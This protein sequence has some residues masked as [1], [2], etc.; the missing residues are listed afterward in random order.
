MLQVRMLYRMLTLTCFMCVT[1]GESVYN[2]SFI[3]LFSTLKEV[4]FHSW[5]ILWMAY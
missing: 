3:P 5:G 1:S 4:V 2:F